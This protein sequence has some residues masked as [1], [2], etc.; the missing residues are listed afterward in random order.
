[1]NPNDEGPIAFQP[2]ERK[3]VVATKGVKLKNKLSDREKAIQEKQNR[4]AELKERFETLAEQAVDD[5]QDR[6]KKALDLA[7]QF[8]MA[9]RDK[10]LPVNKGMVAQDVE[11]ELRNNLVTFAIEVNN[12]DMEQYDGMGSVALMNILLKVVLEQRDRINELEYKLVQLEKIRSSQG[13]S[14]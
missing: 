3:E 1:M 6:N 12:D 8:M 5:R 4:E 2:R 14:G 11:R 9:S 7:R 13:S 10:T